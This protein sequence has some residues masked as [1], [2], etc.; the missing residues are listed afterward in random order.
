MNEIKTS[1]EFK[2]YLQKENRFLLLKHSSTCPISHQAYV[3]VEKYENTGVSVP[4]MYLV[5]Q[6]SRD[7]SNSIAQEYE[8][9]HE[10][11]QAL[12][13]ENGKVK[14]HMSHWDITSTQLKDLL[15]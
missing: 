7:L 2:N 1:E 12:F 4:I 5:V 3:E 9:K 14:G 8:V 6:T 13:F 11:P 10:S 15:K